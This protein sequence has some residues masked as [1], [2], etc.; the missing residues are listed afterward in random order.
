MR[1]RQLSSDIHWMI[2]RIIDEHSTDLVHFQTIYN[3]QGRKTNAWCKTCGAKKS[4]EKIDIFKSILGDE[5][6]KRV[7]KVNWAK[8]K[9][10]IKG[11][12]K[13][14]QKKC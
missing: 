6:Q 1:L 4:S 9:M 7:K 5:G 14:S 13:K 3:N 10:G 11:G 8:A 2:I 12:R